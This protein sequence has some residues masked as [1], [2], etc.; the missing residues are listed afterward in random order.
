MKD[1]AIV[2]HGYYRFTDILFEW[3][4]AIPDAIERSALKALVAY[5]ALG[6]PKHPLWTDKEKGLQLRPMTPASSYIYHRQNI[7]RLTEKLVSSK[8]NTPGCAQREEKQ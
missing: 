5:N 7:V 8:A 4:K 3:H 1:S 2:I 6:D